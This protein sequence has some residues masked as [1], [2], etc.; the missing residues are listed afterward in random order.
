MKNNLRILFFIL[1]SHLFGNTYSLSGVVKDKVTNKP[2]IG[3]NVYVEGTSIGAAANNKGEYSIT[4]LKEGSYVVKASYIGYNA[5][6]DSLIVS[7]DNKNLN[8][9]F[10]LNYTTIEGNEVVVTA[11]ARGQM[12]AI[13]KQLNAKSLVNIISSDRIQE[14]PDANAAETVAR[15]PGVSI[16]REG[17]EGNKV[18]IRGLSPK[19][20]NITV[21][22]V[23]LASTD[24]EDRS[25]DLSMISQYMLDGI[26]VTKAGTPDQDADVLGG[27]VNFLLKKAEPGF[28]GNI[29]TQGMYN[30]LRNSYGDNKFVVDL[31]N[32]FFQ[33]RFGILLQTDLENRN[34]SSNEVGAGYYLSGQTLDTINTLYLSNLNLNDWT[35]LNDRQNTLQVYDYNFKNGNISYS[36]LNSNIDKDITRYSYSYDLLGND[37]FMSSSEGVNS[38]NVLTESWKLNLYNDDLRFNAYHSFSKSVNDDKYYNFGFIERFAYDSTV[39]DKSISFVQGVAKNNVT[40]TH[41]NSYNFFRNISDENERTTGFDLKFNFRVNDYISGQI[42]VGSKLRTKTRTYDRH[43]E[44]GAVGKAAGGKHQR[45]SLISLL[46]IEDFVIDGSD[47]MIPLTP[48]VDDSYDGSGFFNGKYRFDAVGDLDVLMDVYEYFSENWNKSNS[49]SNIDEYVMHHVHQTN[50]QMYDYQGE[51][52]YRA[53]YVMSDVNLG[54]KLNIIAGFRNEINRTNYFSK[55]SL[56][57]ALAHWIYVYEGTSH[58]RTNSYFLP[59][60]FLNYKPTSWLNIK[61]A[62]T[63]TL[64]RPDYTSI[65]PLLRANGSTKTVDWRNKF[66][67]PGLSENKDFSLSF[68]EDKLGLFT[69]GY[70]QK[71]IDNLIYSSGSRVFFEANPGIIDLESMYDAYQIQDYQLNNPNQVSLKGWEFDYQTRFWYLPSFLSGL[72]LNANYT[73]ASSEVKYPRTV[74]DGY[75]DWDLLEYVRNNIDST[76]S[77]QLIDQPDEIINISIGYDYKGFSGRLSMLHNDNVFV[78]A[79]FWPELR[80]NTDTY[81][82]WDLS[83]KQTLPVEGLEMFLNASNLTESNDV[84]RYRGISSKGDNLKLEQYYGKTIDF[85][86]RYKF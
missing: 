38:I 23:K 30:G 50:S 32:R 44:Y 77:E 9:N 48:F 22:G 53:S 20:N 11:Q 79:D 36:N 67:E 26:E 5:F 74:I 29:I 78:A 24:N 37:R 19:Y 51:E 81:R 82:R 4:G 14:L 28:H 16:R 63:N 76:Y 25:T 34:R 61:Y 17:G 12:D 6:T 15:V 21:N 45:D 49:G 8:L 46:G 60:L 41:F 72:V 42:K 83:L 65:I 86:F 27:T 35:R 10:N 55:R 2:L 80:Q 1:F 56:D 58:I 54:P 47:R 18:V 33:D 68:H 73:M 59:A 39:L 7:G 62:Q 71:E 52:Q 3:A 57:H 66:L 69:I 64:T 43:H 85:G 75:F 84:S 70:F 31:S 13:N 40:N